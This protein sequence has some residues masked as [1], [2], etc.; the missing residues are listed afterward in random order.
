MHNPQAFPSPTISR[1]GVVEEATGALDGKIVS[2]EPTGRLIGLSA[3]LCVGG[4]QRNFLDYT[5]I[6]FICMTV[7]KNIFGDGRTPVG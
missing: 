5:T 2:S 1:A 7:I 4:N 3:F 6:S